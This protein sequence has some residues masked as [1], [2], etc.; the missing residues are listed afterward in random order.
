MGKT[1][2]LARGISTALLTTAVGLLIAIPA[3]TAYMYLAGKVDALV[4]EMDRYGQEL[5]QM[6]SAEGLRDRAV[7]GPES[8]SEKAVPAVST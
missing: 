7:S 6:I 3:L 5:I 1:Q 4:M 8:K 2:Q